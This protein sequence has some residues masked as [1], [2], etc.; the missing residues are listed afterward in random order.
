VPLLTS[1]VL[2]LAKA[3]EDLVVQ[4]DLPAPPSLVVAESLDVSSGNQVLMPED[5]TADYYR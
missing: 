3:L 1:P 4:P 5:E 2:H